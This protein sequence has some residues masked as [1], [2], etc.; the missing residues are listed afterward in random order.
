MAHYQFW[1]YRGHWCDV[2]HPG[3]CILAVRLET[4]RSVVEVRY[5]GRTRRFKYLNRVTGVFGCVNPEDFKLST[6]VEFDYDL[7]E[8][9]AEEVMMERYNFD[10]VEAPE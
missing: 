8:K 3:P 9:R 7:D 10:V 2:G 6:L 4:G 1:K 5:G